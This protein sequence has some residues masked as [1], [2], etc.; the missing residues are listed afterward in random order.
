MRSLYV[1]KISVITFNFDFG[2]VS[3]DWCWIISAQAATDMVIRIIYATG[4]P[5]IFTFYTGRTRHAL[6]CEDNSN[7]I[8]KWNKMFV[9][10]NK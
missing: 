7:E 6:N 3:I 1:G 10:R 9:R 5:D 8:K 2:T 4:V